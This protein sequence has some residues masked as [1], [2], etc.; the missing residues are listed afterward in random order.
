MS[1]PKPPYVRL[2][3]GLESKLRAEDVASSFTDL[4]GRAGIPLQARADAAGT[5]V[6]VT[7]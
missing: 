6:Y 5:C 4:F 1:E 7:G 3:R 2:D